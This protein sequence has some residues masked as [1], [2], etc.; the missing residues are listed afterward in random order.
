MKNYQ[1]TAQGSFTIDGMTIPN[2][3]DNRHYRQLLAE[4]AAGDATILPYVEPPEPDAVS[5]TKLQ[6]LEELAELGREE[7]LFTALGSNVSMSRRW[8]AAS[9][10]D[11]GHALVIAAA[12]ALGFT[13]EEMQTV[14][15]A[16][17]KR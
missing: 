1:T 7:D 10:L 3:G 8:D 16:A 6:M 11:V 14:F 17:A 5:C 15:N 9:S 2:S 13:T 4:V 12:G